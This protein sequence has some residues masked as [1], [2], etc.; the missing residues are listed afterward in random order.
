MMF[1]SNLKIIVIS[2]FIPNVSGRRVMYIV[3]DIC[4]SCVGELGMFLYM[5]FKEITSAKDEKEG[6]SEIRTS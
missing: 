2:T 3:K 1:L 4:S 5:Y 6:R